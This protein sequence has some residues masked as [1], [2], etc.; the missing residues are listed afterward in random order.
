MVKYSRALAPL[1]I[2]LLPL[3]PVGCKFIFGPNT[4]N[5]VVEE[6]DVISVS[7]PMAET[8][9]EDLACQ[10]QEGIAD[11]GSQQ[12]FLVR[13]NQGLTQ[14][15]DF[16]G[17]AAN[18]DYGLRGKYVAVTIAGVEREEYKTCHRSLTGALACEKTDEKLLSGGHALKL[19]QKNHSYSRESVE[20]AALASFATI[21]AAGQFYTDSVP[22]GRKA[23]PVWQMILPTWNVIYTSRSQNGEKINVSMPKTDNASWSLARGKLAGGQEK[24][25]KVIS[26]LPASTKFQA[27][28]L[29][30]TRGLWELPFVVAHEYGHHIFYSNVVNVEALYSS[31]TSHNH[32]M[33]LTSRI[34]TDN[35]EKSAQQELEQHIPWHNGGIRFQ[36]ASERARH[37]SRIDAITALNEA[38]ADVFAE[39]AVGGSESMIVVPGV[40]TNREVAN[41]LFTYQGRR[42]PKALNKESLDSFLSAQV[43]ITGNHDLQD[44][45]PISYQDVHT[46]G[47]VFAHGIYALSQ[48]TGTVQTRANLLVLWAQSLDSLLSDSQWDLRS[49][50][51]K[52][53]FNYAELAAG[54]N[55]NKLL[56]PSQ[57]SSFQKSFPEAQNQ[58]AS[59]LSKL[60]CQF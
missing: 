7:N 33:V 24:T 55:P 31:Q 49:L 12:V 51:N 1:A 60:G 43:E 9:F 3:S 38:F 19:C 29:L 58:Y 37:V 54:S 16:S 23:D 42:F 45:A 26:V 47:A 30:K 57:C 41:P 14:G 48:D 25:V 53:A 28:N 20:G 50:L 17:A 35:S 40:C 18:G 6:N 15:E 59:E 8:H 13:K 5:T 36:S 10:S 2:A 21:E 22:N 52:S 32:E 11:L 56:T 39:Y 44:C 27:T 4:D 46:L 34:V